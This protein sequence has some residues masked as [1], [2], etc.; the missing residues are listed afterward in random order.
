MI[1]SENIA[2]C[3]NQGHNTDHE[4]IKCAHHIYDAATLDYESGLSVS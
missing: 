3:A 2:A 1:F 4:A